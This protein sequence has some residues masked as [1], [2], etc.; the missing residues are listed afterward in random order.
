MRQSRSKSI[1]LRDK[2]QVTIPAEI[3]KALGWE[4]GVQ[5]ALIRR[6]NA[7]SIESPGAVVERSF[8]VLSDLA[9]PDAS[10]KSIDQLIDEEDAAIEASVVEEYDLD[11]KELTNPLRSRVAVAGK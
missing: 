2:G 7:L 11:Q 8:G 5:L 6:G 4:P 10:T 9:D 1:K 3:L